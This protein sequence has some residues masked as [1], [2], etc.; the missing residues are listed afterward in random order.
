MSTT[1]VLTF[2]NFLKEF[3][4]E[5]DA[6]ET[7]IGAMLFQEGRLIAYFNKGLSVNNQKLL[8]Y[9]KEFLAVLMAVDKWRS[10]LHKN[11]FVIRTDH[12]SL[13]HL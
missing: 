11:P 3:I 8:T 1:L 9:E 12:Q 5:T 6:C 4:V 7:G 13:C 10:Y 2:P